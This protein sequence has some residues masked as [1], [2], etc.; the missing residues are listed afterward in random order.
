M[1]YYT[2]RAIAAILATSSLAL[3]QWS[4]RSPATSPSARV[5]AAMAFVPQNNG[6]LLFGGSTPLNSNQTWVYDGVDWLQL[7]PASSPSARFGH[8]FVYDVAR[9]VGVLYGGLATFISIPPPTDETWEWDGTTWTQVAPATNLG[10]RYRQGA[11]FDSIRGR[12]VLYGGA[13]TQL[14]GPPNNDT[15]EYDGTAWTQVATTGNPGP[16]ERPAM[17]YYQ[18]IARAVLFGGGTGNGV[19]DETWLYDGFAATWTQVAITGPQPS[20]RSS[21]TMVYDA[22]HDLCVLTG[23]QDASG[24]LSDTWVFD[25]ANWIEQPTTTQAVRD[26]VFA[27]LPTTAQA[28]KFGGFVAAPNTLSSETWEVGSGAF[29]S[30]CAGAAGVPAASAASAPQIGQSWTLDV[31]GLAPTSSLA[32]V[33]LGLTK[34]PGVDLSFLGMT[35]C[36]AFTSPDVLLSVTAGGGSAS[37]TWTSV[38]GPAGAGFYAQVLCLDPAANAFG[39]TASNALYATLVN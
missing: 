13:S 23:G 22:T 34:A 8:S 32:V 11:C 28:V 7:A 31:T 38:A 29:G 20:A 19:S 27:Y 12:T 9:G 2:Q 3:S 14:L 37:W 10:P 25:G 15:W 21:A 26:H 1:T 18:G 35:G 17:C 5:G 6:L 4:Q 39:F 16:I 33:A 36:R 24:A 30:G